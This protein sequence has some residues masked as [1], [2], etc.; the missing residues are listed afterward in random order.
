MMMMHL[1]IFGIKV[2]IGILVL[3]GIRSISLHA[4][5]LEFDCARQLLASSIGGPLKQEILININQH[6]SALR[7]DPYLR[8]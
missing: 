4:F 2:V 7:T 3:F 1:R 5:I 6:Y 8:F